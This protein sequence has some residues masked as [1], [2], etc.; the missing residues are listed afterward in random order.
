MFILWLDCALNQCLVFSLACYLQERVTTRK[1]TSSLS[2]LCFVRWV[3]C[4]R[5]SGNNH[6]ALAW[7]AEIA[8]VLVLTVHRNCLKTGDTTNVV[9]IIEVSR[10]SPIVKHRKKGCKWHAWPDR[11]RKLGCVLGSRLNW[12]RISSGVAC[13]FP[14]GCRRGIRSWARASRDPDSHSSLSVLLP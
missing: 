10:T 1:S 11:S 8:S 7:V 3:F 13:G 5:I 12:A 4:G 14:A 6:R 2:G 9:A